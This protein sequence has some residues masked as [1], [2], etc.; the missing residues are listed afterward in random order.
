M[1]VFIPG[2]RSRVANNRKKFTSFMAITFKLEK[3]KK[4]SKLI[5]Y[6]LINTI[7]KISSEVLERGQGRPHCRCRI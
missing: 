2:A 4:I 6:K 5:L 1:L 3:K 7:K